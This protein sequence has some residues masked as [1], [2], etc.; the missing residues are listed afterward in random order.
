MSFVCSP[1][2]GSGLVILRIQFRSGRLK[3]FTSE[4]LIACSRGM[5]RSGMRVPPGPN[6][7]AET[8]EVGIISQI[9]LVTLNWLTLHIGLTTT[10]VASAG[11]HPNWPSPQPGQHKS[12]HDS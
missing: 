1:F 6:T 2:V 7:L 3:I 12:S 4:I 8:L 10:L 11:L 5:I 9:G